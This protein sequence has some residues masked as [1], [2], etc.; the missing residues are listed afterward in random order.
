MSRSLSQL[1]KKARRV[2]AEPI[3][4]GKFLVM[5]PT[6]DLAFA[7]DGTFFRRGLF[8]I[9]QRDRSAACGP[10]G[11]SALVVHFDPRFRIGGV[12][13]V[14]TAIGTTDNVDKKG[15]C[16]RRCGHE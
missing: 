16:W 10:E 3:Y 11:T 7:G 14:K 2:K 8:M 12:A 5:R 15:I 1:A 6:L 9:S 4:Q 13:N